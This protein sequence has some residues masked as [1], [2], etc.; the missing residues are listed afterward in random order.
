MWNLRAQLY[1]AGAQY[2]RYSSTI[3][4]TC[5]GCIHYTKAPLSMT[6][7]ILLQSCISGC[8]TKSGFFFLFQWSLSESDNLCE[9]HCSVKARKERDFS[10][11]AVYRNMTYTAACVVSFFDL[12]K[13]TFTAIFWVQQKT[14]VP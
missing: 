9:K 8:C 11:T 13:E 10:A 2:S 5:N 1:L 3:S 14:Q 4:D 12:S 6:S 7:P